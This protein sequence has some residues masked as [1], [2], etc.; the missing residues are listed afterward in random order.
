VSSCVYTRYPIVLVD[1]RLLLHSW[2]SDSCKVIWCWRF[3]LLSSSLPRLR[4]SVELVKLWRRC[5]RVMAYTLNRRVVL[6]LISRSWCCLGYHYLRRLKNSSLYLGEF[7]ITCISNVVVVAFTQT[8]SQ[9]RLLSCWVVASSNKCIL[10]L[11]NYWAWWPRCE[12]IGLLWESRHP[13]VCFCVFF[14]DDS[15]N[16]GFGGLLLFII[17]WSRYTLW[18]WWL[19]RYDWSLVYWRPC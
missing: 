15:H 5:T 18:C 1:T 11:S 6:V 16:R 17:L 3:I 8:W 4:P 19:L 10:Q 12:F 9:G 14:V 13:W 2:H 7:A